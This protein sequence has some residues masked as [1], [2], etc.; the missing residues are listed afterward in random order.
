[1]NFGVLMFQI[2]LHIIYIRTCI[3]LTLMC[4]FIEDIDR[5]VMVVTCTYMTLVRHGC[6]KLLIAISSRILKFFAVPPYNG[7][8]SSLLNSPN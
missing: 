7:Y 1:M 5:V 6:A 4:T 3:V 8:S 2:H